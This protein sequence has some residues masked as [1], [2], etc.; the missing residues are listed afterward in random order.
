MSVILN[1]KTY[2]WSQFDANGVARFV[3]A[4]VGGISSGFSQLT[5]KVTI[6]SGKTNRVKW[7]LG[8]PTITTEAGECCSNVGEVKSLAVTTIELELPSVYTSTE[9]QEMLLQLID[10]V[11]TQAFEDSVVLLTQPGPTS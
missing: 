2:S 10:L 9:R 7:K 5:G 3:H 1:G 6:G 11:Q 4:I 8:I